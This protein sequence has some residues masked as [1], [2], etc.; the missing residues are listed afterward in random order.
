[1]QEEQERCEHSRRKEYYKALEKSYV[2][3]SRQKSE[4]KESGG[5]SLCEHSK[6]KNGSKEVRRRYM[7][8][9]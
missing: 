9:T 3:H 5:N 8:I 4:Y 7:F 1:M 6:Q 2:K